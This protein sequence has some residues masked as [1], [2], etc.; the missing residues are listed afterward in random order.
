MSITQLNPPIPMETPRGP[1]LAHFLIDYGPETH[2]MWTVFLDASGECWTFQNPEVRAA[3]NFTLG[4][5]ATSPI[6]APLSKP[7]G[8]NG[9]GPPN[10]KANGHH[11]VSADG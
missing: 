8:S 10:G 6:R 9:A 11:P 2:L 7:S 4:R 3:K 1:G 5:T